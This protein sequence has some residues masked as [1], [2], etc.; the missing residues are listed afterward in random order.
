M[1][2]LKE[3]EYDGMAHSGKGPVAGSCEHD[4]N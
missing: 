3:T 2:K 4:G 1:E